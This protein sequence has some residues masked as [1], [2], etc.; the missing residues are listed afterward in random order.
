MAIEDK[1]YTENKKRKKY[2]LTFEDLQYI[3]PA[4]RSKSGALLLKILYSLAGI[5]KINDLYSHSC[6]KNGAEFV[7]SILKELSIT[8]NIHHKEVLDQ[9][10]QGGFVTVSNHPYGALDGLILIH[11][12][13]SHRPDYKVMVNWILTYI[14]A[15]ADNFIAVEPTSNE[16]RRQISMVGIRESLSH[17]RNGH[18]IGFFPAGAV[19]KINSR[20]RIEDRE[21]Q[22]TVIRLIQQFKVPVIPIYFQGHN[23]LFYNLLGI[24]DWRIRT[25]RLPL[26]IF[27]KR[28]V[29]FDI[30]IGEPISVEQQQKFK[31]LDQFGKFLKKETLKLK[32]NK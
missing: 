11:L 6:D 18:P 5:N 14:E 21:W 3:I 1:K 19:S 20:L 12:L 2:V 28:N 4:F 22:P 29:T 25:I 17:I 15:L 32:K 30:S 16:T 8:Y 27:N 13:G 26:E 10:P 24:I 31:D 7:N 9:L 23:S